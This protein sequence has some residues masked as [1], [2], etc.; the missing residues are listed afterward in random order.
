MKPT[1]F[2]SKK[3][4][5][6]KIILGPKYIWLKRRQAGTELCQA[7]HSL[8][9]ELATLLLGLLTWTAQNLMAWGDGWVNEMQNKSC[10]LATNY[11]IAWSQLTTSF[12]CLPSQLWLELEVWL[13][14]PQNL[15]QIESIQPCKSGD[16]CKNINILPN[17]RF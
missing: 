15:L 9:L 13:S 6:F 7:Q 12:G 11:L 2:W 3:I 5:G 17:K 14:A 4:S 1:N 16:V 10:Y 8:N